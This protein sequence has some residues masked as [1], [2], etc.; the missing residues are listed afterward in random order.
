MVFEKPLT[1]YLASA[2]PESVLRIV[3]ELSAEEHAS[4]HSHYHTI[5]T[6]YHDIQLFSAAFMNYNDYISLDERYSKQFAENVWTAPTFI[7]GEFMTLNLNRHIMN[8]LTA[9]RTALD[10]TDRN[11]K[12]R[13]GEHSERWQSFRKATNQ[14]YD[15]SF[16]YRFLYKL[17]NYV[18]HCG[19]PIGHMSI[20]AIPANKAGMRSPGT[21]QSLKVAFS[22]DSL[23]SNYDSWS[24]LVKS[25]LASLPEFFPIRPLIAEMMIEVEKLQLSQT[26]ANIPAL[27]K[28][29]H[30]LDKLVLEASFPGGMPCIGTR[31]PPPSVGEDYIISLEHFPLELMDMLRESYLQFSGAGTE[32][33]SLKDQPAPSPNLVY[34]GMVSRVSQIILPF[35]HVTFELR[36][37]DV[38][39]V[40]DD[41]YMFALHP[42]TRVFAVCQIANAG[43]TNVLEMLHCDPKQTI[44]EADKTAL[45]GRLGLTFTPPTEVASTGDGAG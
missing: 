9:V 5:V 30:W 45:L 3:R 6:D 29:L 25:E 8:L 14:A 4:Y 39:F 27:I 44:L 36:G 17:R 22:R 10:L 28:S 42:G 26:L 12:H 18:Q 31:T 19:M 34:E 41:N 1:P 40:A 21:S 16:A 13:Y 20:N 38:L 35:P 43:K 24:P 7:G 37:H 23:L 33:I 11:L 2:E 15:G 32:Q